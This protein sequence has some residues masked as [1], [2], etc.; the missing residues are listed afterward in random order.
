MMSRSICGMLS[1]GVV[2]PDRIS[3]GMITRMVRRANCGIERA[4]VA[5]TMP[6][7]VVEKRLTKAPAGNKATECHNETIGRQ[8]LDEFPLWVIRGHRYKTALFLVYPQ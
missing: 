5:S 3:R 6:S 4:T 1:R 7:E 2:P 8:E